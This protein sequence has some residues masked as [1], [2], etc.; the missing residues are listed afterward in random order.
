MFC[1]ELQTYA[2][3]KNIVV[4]EGSKNKVLFLIQF[5]PLEDSNP[6]LNQLSEL[7]EDLYVMASHRH[8]LKNQNKLSGRMSGIGFRG[9]YEDGKTA[10][11]EV[12]DDSKCS[13]E[14][15]NLS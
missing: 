14:R 13:N 6:T 3:S 7:I 12:I 4:C 10:G 5:H 9:A 15:L 11:K 1:I 2:H 8:N